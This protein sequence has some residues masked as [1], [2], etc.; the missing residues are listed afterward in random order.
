MKI[1]FIGLGKLGRAIAERLIESGIEL[2]V[3]NRTVEKAK[4]LGIPTVNCPAELTKVVDKVFIIVFDSQASEEVLF[5]KGGL[6]EG[7]I[8]GKTIVDMTTNHFLY[9]KTAERELKNH[10]AFYLDAPVFGSVI[11]ARKGE[12]TTVIGGNRQKFE[13][14]RPI[15]EKFCKKIFYV[16]E[17]GKATKIK[18]LNNFVLGGIMDILAESIAIAVKA[19]IEKDLFI[20][21]LSAGAGNS[22]ILNAKKEKI[23][24]ED[25]SP[26]FSVNLIYKD[27]HYAQD[28]LKELELFSF[29]LS[30]V[31]ETYGL[32][33][34]E[35]LGEEDF[36]A[37]YKLLS[38]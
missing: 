37:V 9:V 19:G 29:T 32:A 5:G 34:K 28:L 6:V 27:L 7:E 1:G 16:K 36:S 18:L 8:E 15:F 24:K 11:P 17:A 23:L 2:V 22:Y 3:W 13:E 25:F 35:G 12:L 26:H 33:K 10:G 31:K 38:L 21:V 14:V 4:E 30:A 20:D